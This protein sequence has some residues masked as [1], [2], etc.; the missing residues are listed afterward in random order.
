VSLRLVSHNAFWFQGFPFGG[1]Q[2]GPANGDVLRALAG[3]YRELAPDVLCVQEVQSPETATA[4]AEALEME[5]VYAPGGGYPQYGAAVYSPW[6]LA[7]RPSAA[8][9]A[10]D[11]IILR[12]EVAPRERAPLLVANVHLPSNRQ[13]GK[14]GGAAQR[15]AEVHV[16]VAPD[17]ETGR[18]VDVALGDLNEDPDGP[19]AGLLAGW[20]YADA[21]LAQ[22]MGE[23]ASNVKGNKRGDQIWLAPDVARRLERYFVVDGERLAIG[24]GEKTAL[25]DHL[26]IG[27]D[28]R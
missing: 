27:I 5:F 22:G 3:L 20:G 11:R 23:V 26:P 14:A 25:S 8:V 16:A 19:C 6:P 28:L 13:R 21:A 1:D 10:L 15:A 18:P 17:P 9:E 12:V 24:W 4:L 7:G 2:P